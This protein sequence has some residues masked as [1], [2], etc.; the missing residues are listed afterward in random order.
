MVGLENYRKVFAG[1]L[2]EAGEDLV[3]HTGNP[4]RGTGEPIA[5]RILANRQQDL[6]YGALDA[7]QVDVVT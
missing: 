1:V 3:V 7:A 5:V 6:S 4:V 2:T